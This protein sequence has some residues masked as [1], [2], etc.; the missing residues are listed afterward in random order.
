MPPCVE[1]TIRTY[2]HIIY[3]YVAVWLWLDYLSRQ[4]CIQRLVEL[5][6]G[7]AWLLC[8]WRWYYDISS[9]ISIR[10]IY[11]AFYFDDRKPQFGVKW[12]PSM[13]TDI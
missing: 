12:L 4:V 1:I 10:E 11:Y 13:K 8:D 6:N 9:T 3:F 5:L 2:L 7:I